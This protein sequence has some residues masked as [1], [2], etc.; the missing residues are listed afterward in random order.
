MK[1][2]I[3]DFA[4]DVVAVVGAGILVY[5]LGM[6]WRPLGFI[7]AGAVLILGALALGTRRIG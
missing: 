7:A 4:V 2:K 6:A 1:E 3:R 5:G